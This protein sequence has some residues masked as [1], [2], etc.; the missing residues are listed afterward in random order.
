MGTCDFLLALRALFLP[1]RWAV[2][3][4]VA[5]VEL[6]DEGCREEERIEGVL[7]PSSRISSS[8]AWE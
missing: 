3:C 5:V 1:A 6:L 4:G 8:S 7:R 2:M